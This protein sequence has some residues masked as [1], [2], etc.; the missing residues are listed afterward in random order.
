MSSLAGAILDVDGVLLA[1]PHERAWREALD[2]FADPAA[3]TPEVYRSRVAGRPRHDGALGALISLGVR[4]AKARSQDYAE[5]KQVRLD[6]LIA[7]G[8]VHTFPD[9]VRFLLNLKEA[10]LRVAAASSSRNATAMMLAIPLQKGGNLL[11]ALDVDLS[12]R[13]MAHGKPAPD[14]FLAAAAGRFGHAAL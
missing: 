12:G 8:Q 6:A 10:G 4:D 3:F 11:G 14:L 1:S 9:A 2:G 5:R 13:E 7:D